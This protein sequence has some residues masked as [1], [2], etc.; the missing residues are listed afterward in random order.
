VRTAS[1]TP[2]RIPH[3]TGSDT[4]KLLLLAAFAL[5]LVVV[6]SAS[7]VRLLVVVGNPHRS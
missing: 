2:V 5:M 3:A 7:L 4:G 1:L 6:A